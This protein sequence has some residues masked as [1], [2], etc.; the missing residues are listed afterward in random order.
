MHFCTVRLSIVPLASNPWDRAVTNWFYDLR[1]TV[2]HHCYPI[3][4]DRQT[5][6]DPRMSTPF[7]Q[8]QQSIAQYDA[9]A[10]GIEKPINCV[11]RRY[12]RPNLYA[13]MQQIVIALMASMT[14]AYIGFSPQFLGTTM[15]Q[16]SDNIQLY[17]KYTHVGSCLCTALGTVITILDGVSHE[18]N[19]YLYTNPN[20]TIWFHTVSTKITIRVLY[21]TILV[22]IAS[23]IIAAYWMKWYVGLSFTNHLQLYW[24]ILRNCAG[25]SLYLYTYDEMIRT[26]LFHPRPNVSKMIRQWSNDLSSS[27]VTQLG[28]ILNS[29][30]GDP[31]IVQEILN[32]SYSLTRVGAWSFEKEEMISLDKHAKQMAHV[33]LSPIYNYA[34]LEAPLEEDV[35]RIVIL[36]AFGGGGDRSQ[37]LAVSARHQRLINEWIDRPIPR[38]QSNK[39]MANC[40]PLS[41]ALVRGLCVYIGGS[42]E[43]FT[44]L[45]SPMSSLVEQQQAFKFSP[46]AFC[47][48]ELCVVAIGRGIARSLTTSSG[49]LLSDWKCSHLSIQIPSALVAIYKLRSGLVQYSKVVNQDCTSHS[50]DITG[51]T[52]V[53][54][55]LLKEYGLLV[56]TCDAVASLIVLSMKSLQGLGRMDETLLDR[57]CLEWKNRLIELHAENDTRK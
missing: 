30:L 6:P 28:V 52:L 9:L 43:V 15:N 19:P 18:I 27:T 57:D 17:T 21:T 16:N 38:S 26:S 37:L 29:L 24:I 33:L 55:H 14:I 35:L 40:K 4:S 23:M 50:L 8:P 54:V 51:N 2:I 53:G 42:G 45:S 49:R 5:P 47:S 32:V 36:E 3:M 31:S 41:S 22:P 7:V 46:A 39:L 44:M 10:G 12:E 34:L 20:K 1:N 11:G 13:T 25:M 56:H 48:L